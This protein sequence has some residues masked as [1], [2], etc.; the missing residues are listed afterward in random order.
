M[1][2]RVV[3]FLKTQIGPEITSNEIAVLGLAFKGIPETNDLRNSTNIEIYKL[4]KTLNDRVTVFEPTFEGNEEPEFNQKIEQPAIILVLNNH[5]KNIDK[6]LEL[7]YRS[8]HPLT[9]LFDP[10]RLI[11]LNRTNLIK[12]KVV[13][14]TLSNSEIKL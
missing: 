6:A 9:W 14:L 10:W 1:P 12:S 13:Y 8:K 2:E 7:L 4:L 3:S 11:S 5:P